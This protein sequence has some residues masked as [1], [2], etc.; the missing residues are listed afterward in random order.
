MVDMSEATNIENGAKKIIK[1]WNL[2]RLRKEAGYTQL[3]I[4][5]FLNIDISTYLYKENGQRDFLSS[6]M[7]AISNLLDKKIDQIFL[8]PNSN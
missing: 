5:K 1:Q 2:I 8:P 3:E 6:E 7:F 4:A